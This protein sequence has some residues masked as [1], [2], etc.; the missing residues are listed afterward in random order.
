[1][2]AMRRV[3][4]RDRSSSEELQSKLM[5]SL[6]RIDDSMFVTL[7]GSYNVWQEVSGTTK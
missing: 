3:L 4:D 1:M 2:A 5:A 6:S 7:E